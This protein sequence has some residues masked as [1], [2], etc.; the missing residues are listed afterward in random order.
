MLWLLAAAGITL[1]VCAYAALNSVAQGR[2]FAP[3][4]FP[5]G[6]WSQQ[7]VAGAEDAWLTTA[8]GVR[9]NAWWKAG[10][11]SKFVTL[12]LHGNG[13]NVTTRAGQVRAIAEAGSD[14]LVL[15]YRGY[16]K[17]DGRPSE[18]G[19]YLDAD[20]GYEYVRKSRKPII[21][22]GQSMGTAVALELAV[23]RP[24]AGVVLESPFTSGREIAIRSS[25]LAACFPWGFDSRARITELHVP[26][27]IMHG[28]KDSAVPPAMGKELFSIA[29]GPKQF[30]SV[31]E[32]G[33]GSSLLAA[34]GAE[35]VAHLRAFYATLK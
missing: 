23:R 17:S 34:A 35:Y 14:V 29:P 4:K 16:G 20:A 10:T 12:Y 30:W 11:D 21:I 9:L 26:L 28:E 5:Q 31:P 27:L 3:W 19:V 2:F 24:C 7:H 25:R 15:D 32:A 13:F 18:H 22:Q 33:H 1:L 8:D 6:D